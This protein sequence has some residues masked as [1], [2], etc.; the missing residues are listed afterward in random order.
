MATLREVLADTI[1]GQARPAAP[2]EPGLPGTPI[3]LRFDSVQDAQ[4]DDNLSGK[5]PFDPAAPGPWSFAFTVDD[6]GA[7]VT[8]LDC[9]APCESMPPM[10]VRICDEIDFASVEVTLA[11]KSIRLPLD[12]QHLIVHTG[13]HEE[14]KLA[15]GANRFFGLEVALNQAVQATFGYELRGG[16][17]RPLPAAVRERNDFNDF[18]AEGQK[19]VKVP[20]VFGA[21]QAPTLRAL[22][23]RFLVALSFTAHKPRNDFEPQGVLLAARMVPA[24]FVRANCALD[25][26]RVKVTLRRP[27]DS[28]MAGMM[29]DVDQP[30]GSVFFTDRNNASPLPLWDQIFD[31]YMLPSTPGFDGNVSAAG[32]FAALHAIK[33]GAAAQAKAR[34][35]SGK[36][37]TISPL[38]PALQTALTVASPVLA[39]GLRELVD[40]ATKPDRIEGLSGRY[41]PETVLKTAGQGEFDSVHIA[42]KMVVPGGN[43]KG[44]KVAMAPICAHDCLHT[45]WRWSFAYG[46]PQTRGWDAAGSFKKPGAPMAPANQ[47]IRIQP[48]GTHGFHYLATCKG[49]IAANEWQPVFAHGSAYSLSIMQDTLQHIGMTAPIGLVGFPIM[50]ALLRFDVSAHLPSLKAMLD[51]ALVVSNQPILALLILMKDQLSQIG[52]ADL[53]ERIQVSSGELE[54]LRAL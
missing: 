44:L 15:A 41:G 26:V 34:K 22:P 9:V 6:K 50:Y 28:P 19:S 49:P 35:L 53:R 18:V 45:H 40:Q 33:N 20:P 16:Q 3:T 37:K 21:G 24:V 48:I 27:A 13:L 31:Y 39:E 10:P 8:G 23:P 51:A 14:G 36:R 32:E 43:L 2:L 7:R 42:P 4:T 54:E 30:M 17:V 47:D 38:P 11:G 12:P 46:A 25:E 1:V 29:R 52:R 5:K